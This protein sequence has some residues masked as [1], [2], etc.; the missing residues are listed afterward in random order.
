M[1]AAR[2]IWPSGKTRSEVA[3][4]AGKTSKAQAMSAMFR[5][6]ARIRIRASRERRIAPATF[7]CAP[8]RS[9]TNDERFIAVWFND[10]GS[11]APF[12]GNRV[13]PI[14]VDSE[15]NEQVTNGG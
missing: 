4:P 11:T 13:S 8:E 1:L 5:R 15:V 14:A 7:G 6:R 12:R 9:I 3:I 2:A 10:D